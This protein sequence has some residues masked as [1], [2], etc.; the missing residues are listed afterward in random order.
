MA[1][2]FGGVAVE[3]QPVQGS[4]FGGV[5]VSAAG[6]KPDFAGAG[7]IEPV[8]AVAS[9]V[10]R[11]VAGGLAG[12]AQALNPFAEEGAPIVHLLDFPILYHKEYR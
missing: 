10:G 12:T 5:A 3:A 7:V 11:T 4:K 6:D 8:R 2:K 9:A 1:S